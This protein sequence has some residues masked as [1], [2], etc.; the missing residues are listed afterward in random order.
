[1]LPIICLSILLLHSEK[2]NWLPEVVKSSYLTHDAKQLRL[3]ETEVEL[4]AALLLADLVIKR[5]EARIKFISQN[6]YYEKGRGYGSFRK[7]HYYAHDNEK[8]DE[9]AK[10]LDFLQRNAPL[11]NIPITLKDGSESYNASLGSIHHYF[12]KTSSDNE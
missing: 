1:M 7:Y 9:I 6:V 3:Q 8:F 5:T 4:Q 12:V 10:A 11:I 2:A